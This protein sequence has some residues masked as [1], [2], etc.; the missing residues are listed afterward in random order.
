M[1]K[2]NTC[3]C[4]CT[5]TCSGQCVSGGVCISKA[6]MNRFIVSHPRPPVF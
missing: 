6:T 3:T 1:T 4:T 2:N 5:C